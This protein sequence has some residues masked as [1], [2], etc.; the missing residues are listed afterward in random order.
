ML[1]DWVKSLGK[2]MIET[3]FRVKVALEKTWKTRS[4]IINSKVLN[5][6]LINVK[7]SKNGFR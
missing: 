3:K 7:N 6:R 4:D 5:N 1:N 2:M